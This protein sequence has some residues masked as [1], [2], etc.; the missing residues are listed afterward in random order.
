MTDA[1]R[2]FV[3]AIH[4]CA[5]R[6]EYSDITADND[7]IEAWHH[8]C[9]ET[10]YSHRVNPSDHYNEIVDTERVRRICETISDPITAGP[11]ADII[12]A[13]IKKEMAPFIGLLNEFDRIRMN[14]HLIDFVNGKYVIDEA[15]YGSLAMLA[16]PLIDREWTHD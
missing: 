16:N 8:L 13:T 15:A 5:W 9:D 3:E 12:R 14:P 4:R 11:I 1:E 7:L 2:E 10:Y 6:E